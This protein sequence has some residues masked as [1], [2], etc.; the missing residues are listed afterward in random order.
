MTDLEICLA[1]A[2]ERVRELEVALRC[3]EVERDTLR[4]GSGKK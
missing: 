4:T 1:R 3:A 2:E